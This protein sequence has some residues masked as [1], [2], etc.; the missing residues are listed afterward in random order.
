MDDVSGMQDLWRR[1]HRYS[2]SIYDVIVFEGD[3]DV[4]TRRVKA[5]VMTSSL[6]W[7]RSSH[8]KE[9]RHVSWSGNRDSQG[10]QQ[11]FSGEELFRNRFLFLH[12]TQPFVLEFVLFYEPVFIYIILWIS[13]RHYAYFASCVTFHGIAHLPL[14]MQLQKPSSRWFQS[15]LLYYQKIINYLHIM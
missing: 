14:S 1:R 10:Q 15:N 4:I 8:V 2:K 3:N 6:S 7:C 5:L 9:W 11:R 12:K 13:Y